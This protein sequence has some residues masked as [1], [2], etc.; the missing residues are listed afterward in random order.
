MPATMAPKTSGAKF[1]LKAPKGTRDWDGS[2]MVLRD[3]IFTTIGEVFSTA[4]GRKQ[5]AGDDG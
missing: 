5:C 4:S 2:D 3:R 1:E